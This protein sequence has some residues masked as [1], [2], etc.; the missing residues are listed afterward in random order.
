MLYRCN[1]CGISKRADEFYAQRGRASGVQGRCKPCSKAER[2]IDKMRNAEHTRAYQRARYRDLKA[3][4]RDYLTT[5]PCVDCGESDP[6]VLEFD[7]VRGVKNRDVTT[8]V[9]DGCSWNTILQEI[10]KCEIRCANCHRKVTA[11]RRTSVRAA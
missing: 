3:R 8:M 10:A 6:I 5:H 1:I 4:L 7:H 2:A 11:R 9:R